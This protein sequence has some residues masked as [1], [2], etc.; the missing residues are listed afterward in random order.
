MKAWGLSSISYPL[1]FS[2]EPP[3]PS[4][5][6]GFLVLANDPRLC[7]F[8]P[9]G[10]LLTPEWFRMTL[11]NLLWHYCAFK[12]PP[13]PCHDR[14]HRALAPPNTHPTTN[15]RA[16]N[17]SP[18]HDSPLFSIR[19]PR[20]NP[21]LLSHFFLKFLIPDLGLS[22]ALYEPPK[23]KCNP[24][25]SVSKNMLKQSGLISYLFPSNSICHAT[26]SSNQ[27][28]CECLTHLSPTKPSIWFKIL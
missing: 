26:E 28:C 12:A 4:T 11:E 22:T 7:L 5:V 10:W 8:S 24:E 2:Q 27:S 18:C 16:E 19:S 20:N 14:D 15:S 21:C 1:I 13:D 25:P 3:L 17:A 23:I 6:P 9:H